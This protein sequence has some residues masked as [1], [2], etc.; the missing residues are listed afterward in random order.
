MQRDPGEGECLLA[1]V[2]LCD[3]V[4]IFISN[5]S[6]LKLGMCV[7]EAIWNSVIMQFEV[8]SVCLGS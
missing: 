1:L 2:F 4:E 6:S 8:H 3:I 5:R 7:R